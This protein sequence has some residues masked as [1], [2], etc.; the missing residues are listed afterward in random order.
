MP[1]D[2]FQQ[3]GINPSANA[4]PIDL[5]EQAGINVTPQMQTNPSLLP[6]IGADALAGV[7]QF[8]H[9]LIN[10]PHNLVNVVS[11]SLAAKIPTQQDYNYSQMLGVNNPN[12]LDKLLQGFTQY[13][14]YMGLPVGMLG[15]GVAFG[16]TQSQNPV[17]GALTAGLLGKAADV[18]P[19]V[20]GAIGSGI[21]KA[22][23]AI[24]PQSF[25]E[26]LMQNLIGGR[27]L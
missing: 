14:P 11:P 27:S 20:I 21:S 22:T 6:R 9:G 24:R 16:A 8:G 3:A 5:F 4:Q 7:A 23:N 10:A 19:A 12:V 17:T 13:A 18:A 2:L 26:Q 25:A 15:Q 1:V